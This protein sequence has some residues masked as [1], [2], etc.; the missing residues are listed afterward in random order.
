MGGLQDADEVNIVCMGDRRWP[1]DETGDM[2][3]C[4]PAVA[5]VL[6]VI[7]GP[8]V[9]RPA[10]VSLSPVRQSAYEQSERCRSAMQRS[11]LASCTTDRLLTLRAQLSDVIRICL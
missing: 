6:S 2:R 8:T 1:T 4:G 3:R 7:S 10:A 11:Q 9:D 5:P